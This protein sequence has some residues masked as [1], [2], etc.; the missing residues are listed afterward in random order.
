MKFSALESAIAILAK[1]AANVPVRVS[2][3]ECSGS[4]RTQNPDGSA[5]GAE[6]EFPA[7]AVQ[8]QIEAVAA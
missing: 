4:F 8:A 5:H 6:N 3:L 2:M 1:V 7:A